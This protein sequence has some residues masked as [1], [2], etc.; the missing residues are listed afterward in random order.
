MNKCVFLRALG[1]LKKH[2]QQV[3]DAWD[4]FK[5]T[6]LSNVCKTNVCRE[7]TGKDQAL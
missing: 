7:T 5:D 4:T 6:K 3:V 1:K 2:R